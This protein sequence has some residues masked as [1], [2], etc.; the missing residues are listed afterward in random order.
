MNQLLQS[1]PRNLFFTGKGGVG[2]TSV[3]CAVAVQLATAGR[4]VLLVSTDPASNLD[5][6]LGATL[7]NRPTAIPGVPLLYAMNIDPEK[8]AAAY[9][10]RMVA[11]YRG[12]LPEAAV[13]SMEEQFSGAC[14]LEIAAF[15]EFSRLLGD[16]AA[17]SDFQHVIF[18]T[19]PTGH[20]LRLLTLPSAWDGY[21]QQNTTGTSC[22]GPLAGLQAQKELYH[23]SVQALSDPVATML[24]LVSR[25]ENSA[26]REAARTCG[27]LR[28]LGVRN[29]TLIINGVYHATDPQD[30]WATA[31]EQRGIL[32]IETMPEILT[33]L[34]RIVFPLLPRGVMGIES[35]RT[36]G[37]PNASTQLAAT[38]MGS[39]GQSDDWPDLSTFI[40]EL[41]AP[42][43]VSSW[44]WAKV[45]WA[46]PRSQPR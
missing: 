32:A 30:P 8:S 33:D 36:F 1:P 17:T 4:R 35:L 23:R 6:V 21:L 9:R 11:P 7:G 12:L 13:K 42:G 24:V 46:R 3:A 37:D 22:L 43:T 45:A 19:A 10:E 38:T 39:A 28:E 15:D 18:D 41:V 20:T 5:E 40:D 27:E 26:L 29:Q 44:R 31:W 25:P 2:K 16:P 34:P 14:T